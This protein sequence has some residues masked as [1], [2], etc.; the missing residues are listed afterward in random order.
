MLS[1]PERYECRYSRDPRHPT[2]NLRTAIEGEDWWDVQVQAAR[3]QTPS[4]CCYLER[5][6]RAP[7]AGL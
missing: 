3:S 1:Y 7:K 5:L 4:E 6:K 2:E